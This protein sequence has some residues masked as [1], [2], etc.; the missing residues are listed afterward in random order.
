M[1]TGAETNLYWICKLQNLCYQHLSTVSL[2]SD[3]LTETHSGNPDCVSAPTYLLLP[4][5]LDKMPS[6]MVGGIDLV[7][8]VVI[9][10]YGSSAWRFGQISISQIR[11]LYGLY[12][13]RIGI[14]KP[15]HM[16]RL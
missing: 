8:N 14:P 3:D 5:K 10:L 6:K 13:W 4:C 2:F 16:R 12:A 1:D 9:F 7:Q 15:T 11:I